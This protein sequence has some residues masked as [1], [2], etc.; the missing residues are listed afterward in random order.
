MDAYVYG[1]SPIE[2]S[3]FIVPTCNPNKALHGQGFLA[4]LTGANA[5]VIDMY[6]NLFV[7]SHLFT[8]KDGELT[9]SL[10][11]KLPAE[12][13]DKNDK[14]TFELFNK[15]LVVYH[16]PKRLDC[17]KGINLK[18]KV[19]GQEYDSIRGDLAKKIRDKKIKKIEVEIY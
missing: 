2:A 12:F 5:E 10:S 4:R 1:R 15:V 16:N 7:G 19:N 9:L 17:Y 3:S 18:Y 11:P 14:V 8:M 13:F 6:F